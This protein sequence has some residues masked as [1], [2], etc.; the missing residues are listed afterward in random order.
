MSLRHHAIVSSHLSGHFTSRS[1]RAH[2][3]YVTEITQLD[4]QHD[5]LCP[6]ASGNA[7]I[8]I[9]FRQPQKLA[10]FIQITLTFIKYSRPNGKV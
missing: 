5:N 9:E 6:A 4:S 8:Q 10:P 2:L 3:D 7:N 1:Q